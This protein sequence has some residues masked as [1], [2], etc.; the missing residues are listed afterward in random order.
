MKKYRKLAGILAGSM[1]LSLFAGCIGAREKV[2]EEKN[3]STDAEEKETSE[4][5]G[6]AHV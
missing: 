6:R 3:E 5:I 4:E 2:Q 1:L